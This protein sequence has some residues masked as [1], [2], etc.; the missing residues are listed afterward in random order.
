MFMAPRSAFFLLLVLLSSC[1]AWSRR[2]R[3][4]SE[5]YYASAECERKSTYVVSPGT[6][7][8]VTPSEAGGGFSLRDLD[9]DTA[10][11]PT[12]DNSVCETG[13]LAPYVVGQHDVKTMVLSDAFSA[14]TIR[15]DFANGTY[16][17]TEYKGNGVLFESGYCK[18]Q[19]LE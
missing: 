6:A 4:Q 18:F 7:P 19:K 11:E 13:F 17:R 14:S 3:V 8:V 15:L 10:H 16:D 5:F 1:S 2:S 9:K 12:C